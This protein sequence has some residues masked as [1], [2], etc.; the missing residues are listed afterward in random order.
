MFGTAG[1]DVVHDVNPRS[2]QL[3]VEASLLGL[4]DNPQP[5]WIPPMKPILLVGVA[6]MLAGIVLLVV[7]VRASD[8]FADQL[9]DTFLGHFTG[10]TTRNITAGIAMIV[11]GGALAFS[12]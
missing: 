10:H 3:S 1:D 9:S 7:G 5:P 12:G 6:I 2:Y 4:A 11:G 8:S